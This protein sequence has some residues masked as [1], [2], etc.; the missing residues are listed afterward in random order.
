[1][2]RWRTLRNRSQLELALQADVSP[3]HF[4]IV[5]N[6][7]AQPGREL[8]VLELAREPSASRASRR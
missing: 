6:G 2:R 5:E 7:R 3:R 1:V 4:S 8:L